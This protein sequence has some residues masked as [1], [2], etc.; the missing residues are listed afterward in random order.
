MMSL[1]LKHSKLS[2]ILT[3]ALFSTST[4]FIS[5]AYAASDSSEKQDENIEVTQQNVTQE[6]LAAIYI[7]SEICPKLIDKGQ[8]FAKGYGLLVKDYLPETKNPVA[9]LK[10]ISLQAKF[11]PALL[12]AR[13]DAKKAGDQANLAICQ[14]VINYQAY[15]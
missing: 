8:D 9:A 7:L 10:S 15:K 5:S 12:E 4:L 2:N 13:E 6:E 1:K 3:V 11:E 14:N